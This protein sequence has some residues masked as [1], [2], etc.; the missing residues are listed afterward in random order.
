MMW[1]VGC[2]GLFDVWMQRSSKFTNRILLQIR[3]RTS[4]LVLRPLDATPPALPLRA[5][6][7]RPIKAPG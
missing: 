4:D 7:E 1:D 3:N 2:E 6:I 5:V